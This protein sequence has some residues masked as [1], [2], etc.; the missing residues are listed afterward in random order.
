MLI[1]RERLRAK[2]W[3]AQKPQKPDDFI[4]HGGRRFGER[5]K[6]R[7]AAGGRRPAGGQGRG[8]GDGPVTV[9]EGSVA[10]RRDG[11]RRDGRTCRTGASAS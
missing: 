9:V 6:A 1:W 7:W 2:A 3:P 11:D 8:R 5:C 10:A 4:L